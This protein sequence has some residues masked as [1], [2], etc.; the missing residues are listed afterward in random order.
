[1]S[2]MNEMSN[3]VRNGF[4]ERRLMM[5]FYQTTSPAWRYLN[6]TNSRGLVPCL[7][8]N[9]S[10][11]PDVCWYQPSKEGRYASHDV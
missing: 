6:N 7:D 5:E 3:T 11:E 2:K 8:K 4:K 9:E 1:M 10:Q